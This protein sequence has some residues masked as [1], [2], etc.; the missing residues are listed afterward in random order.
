MD[1]AKSYS[2]FEY[3]K[4]INCPQLIPHNQFADQV[5]C[6]LYS[7]CRTKKEFYSWLNENNYFI[8]TIK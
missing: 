4:A 1:K 6:K 3:C 5:Q 7:C 2:K 8:L